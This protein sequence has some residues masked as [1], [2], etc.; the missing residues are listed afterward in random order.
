M[1]RDS[2]L[3]LLEELARV[4]DDYIVALDTSGAIVWAEP[5]LFGL[6]GRAELPHVGFHL[7]DFLE[8][9]DL[10]TVSREMAH[11]LGGEGGHFEGGLRIRAGRGSGGAEIVSAWR[12]DFKDGASLVVGF[13]RPTGAADAAA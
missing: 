1:G 8:G 9:E 4:S 6:L 2:V 5:E 3:P 7:Q 12:L 10:T 11:L 13:L